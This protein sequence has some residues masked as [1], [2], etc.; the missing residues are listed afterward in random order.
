[1][2]IMNYGDLSLLMKLYHPNGIHN[3]IIISTIMRDCLLALECLNNNNYFHR[4][5]KASN[6]LLS[7]DGSIKLGDYGVSSVIKKE[8]NNSYVGSLCWMAPE[9]ARGNVY[10]YKVDIWSL[11][12]TAI[13]I[14]NGKP[15][16]VGLSPFEYI[17]EVVDGAVPEL[18]DTKYKWSQ[19][20]KDFVKSC[21]VKDPNLRPS[22][23]GILD[24]NKQF[25][26]KD[27]NNEYILQTLLKGVTFIQDR[28]PEKQ[29]KIEKTNI[30]KD[31]EVLDGKNRVN[32]NYIE[33]VDGIKGNNK[34]KC[35]KLRNIDMNVK[36]E[37]KKI[38]AP[39]AST[40]VEKSSN[41][42]KNIFGDLINMKEEEM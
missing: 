14:A 40:T 1:M 30:D 29:N 6:I 23:R 24:N 33:G 13:E 20:F 38:T 28:F 32:G 37:E 34:Y 31:S 7:V 35:K 11:G 4:D 21:L 8:G 10:G 5:I 41:N 25:F 27:K 18:S 17:R 42:I 15:P 39:S 12:I 22:A 9:V 2:P 16:F 26:S 3:E 36:D 19:E